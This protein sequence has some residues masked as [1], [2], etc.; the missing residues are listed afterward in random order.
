MKDSVRTKVDFKDPLAVLS[1]QPAGASAIR[2]VD[3][4]CRLGPIDTVEGLPGCDVVTTNDQEDSKTEEALA[5]HYARYSKAMVKSLRKGAIR[6]VEIFTDK[7]R[8]E[9]G[10]PPQPQSLRLSPGLMLTGAP[11]GSAASQREGLSVFHRF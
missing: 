6:M 9:G 4:S 8:P 1:E 10:G 5:K 2:F 11:D 3:A 7:A